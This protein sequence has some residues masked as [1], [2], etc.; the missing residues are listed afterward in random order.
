MES[1]IAHILGL[2]LLFAIILAGLG[3]MAGYKPERILAATMKFTMRT[4]WGILRA[5][6]RS[7]SSYRN[8]AFNAARQRASRA[9]RHRRM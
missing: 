1:L 3:M 8:R 5:V 2:P 9:G 7:H 4:F 6:F